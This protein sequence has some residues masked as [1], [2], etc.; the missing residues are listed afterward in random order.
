MFES[1]ILFFSLLFFSFLL[2]GCAQHIVASRKHS[3]NPVT[4]TSAAYNL[5]RLNQL[6]GD[7]FKVPHYDL[8][9]EV[10]LKGTHSL[11]SIYTMADRS[12]S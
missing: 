10:N 1:T 8:T 9:S 2:T 11:Y 12:F 7:V 3:N 6:D 5:L 4:F